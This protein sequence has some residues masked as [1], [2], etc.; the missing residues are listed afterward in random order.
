VEILRQ[1]GVPNIFDDKAKRYFRTS[2]DAEANFYNSN[3]VSGLS[4]DEKRAVFE[5]LKRRAI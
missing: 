3:L 1:R 5:E 2:P 4:E